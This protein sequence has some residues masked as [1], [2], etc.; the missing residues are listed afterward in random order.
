M[1]R[2]RICRLAVFALILSLF[3]L[4]V[5]KVARADSYTYQ[6][7]SVSPPVYWNYTDNGDGTLKVGN[8]GFYDNTSAYDTLTIPSVI[9]GQ[10]VTKIENVFNSVSRFQHLVIPAS[11]TQIGDYSVY[12]CSGVQSITILGNVTAIGEAAFRGCEALQSVNVPNSVATIGSMAFMECSSL[13]SI[14]IPT[15]LKNLE[16][17][18]FSGCA[19]LTSI[20]L[21]NGLLTIDSNTFEDCTGLESI[22]FPASVTAINFGAFWGCNNITSYEVDSHNLIYSSLNGVIFDKN[23]KMIMRCPEGKNGAF[24]I[25][26]GVTSIGDIS[27][28]SCTRLTGITIPDGVTSIG[29]EG[30]AGCTGLTGLTLPP[31]LKS[32]GMLAFSGC[33]GLGSLALPPSTTTIGMG[34]FMGCT[35]FTSFTLPDGVTTVMESSFSDCSGLASVTLPGSISGIKYGAFKG[36]S[37]LARCVFKGDVPAIESTAYPEQGFTAYY[38]VSRAANWASY[39]DQPKQAYCIVTVYPQNGSASSQNMV[40]VK[41]GHIAAPAAPKRTGYAFG[42]WYKEAACKNAWNFTSDKVTGNVTMY[43]GWIVLPAAPANT[44]AVSISYNS[45][46]I[47]WNAVPGAVRY[48]IWRMPS[49]AGSYSLAGTTVSISLINPSLTTG[50]KYYYKVRAYRW[51]GSSKL[52]SSWSAVVSATPIPS[53]PGAVKAVPV[54][55]NSITVSWGAVAGATKYE[56]R[57]STSQTGTYSLLTITTA[58]SYTDTHVNTGTAYYYK[59]RAY[60][61]MG[62]TKIYGASSAIVSTKTL[63]G[64]PSLVKAVPASSTS[65]KVSWGAVAGATKYEVWRC[66]ASA[67]GTFILLATTGNIYYTDMGLLHGKTYWY[68]VRAYRLIGS[69][70]VY[71]GS[72]AVVYTKP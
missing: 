30:F 72:S 9:N 59:V 60:R 1:S 39:T 56:L 48:E 49:G 23:K 54:T 7:N 22:F 3:T 47:A 18:V 61:L 21:P 13:Q 68:K 66:T 63:L 52:Y 2:L 10:P 17:D 58:F 27:F 4:P 41:N 24:S 16:S 12:Y 69:T 40:D 26:S 51:N 34:A 44:T 62:S 65:V 14:N 31:S 33:S 29:I 5:Q 42:G 64:V 43:A 8:A 20:T 50:T 57:R 45:V 38:P 15:S 25:P 35:G 37:S 6:D 19:E 71:G 70:K 46:K 67:T 32:I 53:A 28:T 11:V 55:Y 36:C